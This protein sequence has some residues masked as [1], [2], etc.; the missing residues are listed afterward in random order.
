MEDS[1]DERTCPNPGCGRVFPTKRGCELHYGRYCGAGGG[2]PLIPAV[3]TNS[4]F[5]R[6]PQAAAAGPRAAAARRPRTAAAGPRSEAARQRRPAAS[7]QPPP[8]PPTLCPSSES[9]SEEEIEVAGGGAEGE[10]GEGN[11]K[12]PMYKIQTQTICFMLC[13]TIRVRLH[14]T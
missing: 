3:E 13:F 2:R 10:P 12:S 8:P 6:G 9:E 1:A 11:S 5:R 4:N 7:R 14:F